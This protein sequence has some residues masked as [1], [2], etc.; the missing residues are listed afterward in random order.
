MESRN[1]HQV[2]LARDLRSVLKGILEIATVLDQFSAESAHRCVLLKTVAVRHHNDGTQPIATGR[3]R[4]ALTVIAAGCCDN[5][6]RRGSAAQQIVNVDQPATQL[7]RANGSVIFVLYPDLA[8]AARR[9]RWP[10]NFRRRP[11][12]RHDQPR[13]SLNLFQLW[14]RPHGAPP[15]SSRSLRNRFPLCL[16]FRVT[17]EQL[18]AMDCVVFRARV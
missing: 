5:S 2:A 7:E 12:R 6:E 1:H 10:A 17:V 4:D 3:K 18:S 8:T 15:S 11:H 16:T 14:Q 13:R 9:E